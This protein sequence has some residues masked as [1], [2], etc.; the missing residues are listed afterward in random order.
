MVGCLMFALLLGK[1]DRHLPWSARVFFE[2]LELLET[3]REMS[4]A[5]LASCLGE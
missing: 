4:D 5:V 2:R 3:E 1:A